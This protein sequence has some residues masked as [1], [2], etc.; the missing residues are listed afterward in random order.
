MRDTR[1]MTDIQFNYGLCVQHFWRYLVTPAVF[2]KSVG[3]MIHESVAPR[4]LY[5]ELI[6]RYL[7]PAT[8]DNY[9]LNYNE[10]LVQH[11]MIDMF[12]KS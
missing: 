6:C 7:P 1:G 2:L 9:M 4:P 10:V 3:Y 11:L 5:G 12:Y 8:S